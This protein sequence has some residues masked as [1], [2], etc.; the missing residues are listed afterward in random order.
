MTPVAT[1]PAPL[2]SSLSNPILG[3]VATVLVVSVFILAARGLE[4]PTQVDHVTVVNPHPWVT[5]VTVSDGAGER[6]LSIG[7]VPRESER[8]FTGIVDQGD[9]WIVTLAYAGEHVDVAVPRDDL[10]RG[11][12]TIEVPD[13]FAQLLREAGV[14]ET[15][16]GAG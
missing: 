11:G 10:A 4:L 15:P 3:A 5:H 9:T 1:R 7:T 2:P 13:E 12:W 14:A 8:T 6:S 16:P